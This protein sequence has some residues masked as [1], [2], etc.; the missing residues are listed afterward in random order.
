[1]KEKTFVY[2]VEVDASDDIS[3]SDV[4][5]QIARSLGVSAPIS[6]GNPLVLGTAS[7]DDVRFLSSGEYSKNKGGKKL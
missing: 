2:L 4:S 1:M 7:V 3:K 6:V 5:Q